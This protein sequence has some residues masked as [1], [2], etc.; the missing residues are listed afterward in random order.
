M[1]NCLWVDLDHL[2]STEHQRSH[3]RDLLLESQQRSQQ[4]VILQSIRGAK[5]NYTQ[6]WKKHASFSFTIIHN[7]VLVYHIKSNKSALKY[8]KILQGF[9]CNVTKYVKLQGAWR[10]LKSF[11]LLVHHVTDSDI[12]I[13]QPKAVCWALFCVRHKHTTHTILEIPSIN[14]WMTQ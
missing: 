6:T 3:T 9:V 11:V 13:S 1:W 5:Y 12:T 7:S 14:L 10:H 4:R 2:N 8:W